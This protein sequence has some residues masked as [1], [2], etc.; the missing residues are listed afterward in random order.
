MTPIITHL[1]VGYSGMCIGAA[2]AMLL[3]RPKMKRT[4]RPKPMVWTHAKLDDVT[5][6]AVAEVWW[7]R[8][9]RDD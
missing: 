9:N 8:A 4:P 3:M 5:Q 7:L 1:L 6:Q 2:L